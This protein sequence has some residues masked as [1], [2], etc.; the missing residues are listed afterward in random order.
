[1]REL[2]LITTVNFTSGRRNFIDRQI[3]FV[4]G[5]GRLASTRG[6]MIG[7]RANHG[8]LYRHGRLERLRRVTLR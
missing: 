5:A 4:G 8:V 6:Q 2:H 1:L 7:N 3:D